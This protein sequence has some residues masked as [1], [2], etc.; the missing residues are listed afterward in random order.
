LLDDDTE[1]ARKA[2]AYQCFG[3]HLSLQGKE[4]ILSFGVWYEV[5][6]D[7]L[8]KINSKVAAIPPPKVQL[9]DWNKGETEPEYNLRCGQVHGFL[10]M[11]VKPVMVGGKHSKLEFCDTLHLQSKTLYFAKIAS[12]SSGMS[13][14]LEQT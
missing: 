2:N 13:H 8:G 3:Y 11:D 5:T 6:G 10:S 1:E 9:P 12:K 4:Y 7:F 14:L